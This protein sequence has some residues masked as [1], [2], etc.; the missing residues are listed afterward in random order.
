MDF[1]K[2]TLK[3]I[4]VKEN[5]LYDIVYNLIFFAKLKESEDDIKDGRT[6]TLEELKNEME[7][8]YESYHNRES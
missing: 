1:M 3:Q 4:N 6:Y 8:R 5:T 7:A 2:N